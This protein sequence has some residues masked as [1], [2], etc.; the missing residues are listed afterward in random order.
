MKI[1]IIYEGVFE[2]TKF[3]SVEVDSTEWAWMKLTHGNYVD[4]EMDEQAE[5][6]C[7]QLS[8]WLVGKKAMEATT[9]I[10]LRGENYDYVLHTGILP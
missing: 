4:A 9:P 2:D 3:Y 10:L 8:E 6:A 7:N 1:L 5:K